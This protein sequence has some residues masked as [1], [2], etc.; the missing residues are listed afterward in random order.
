MTDNFYYIGVWLYEYVLLNIAMLNCKSFRRKQENCRLC[1]FRGIFLFLMSLPE[2]LLREN[3][4]RLTLSLRMIIVFWCF[5]FRKVFFQLEILTGR[6]SGLPHLRKCF[7]QIRP[8]RL[9]VS[10]WPLQFN[11]SFGHYCI[12]SIA[13][14]SSCCMDQKYYYH[15]SWF[16][17]SIRVST[18]KHQ[19][20]SCWYI[21]TIT[22][23]AAVALKVLLL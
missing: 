22:I 6:E 17:K 11:R 3:D 12:K 7:I 21:K 15:S 13:Q 9:S 16:I 8:H 4:G 23:Q 10:D 1:S 14:Y 19:Y 2:K 5:P 20:Y 18:L